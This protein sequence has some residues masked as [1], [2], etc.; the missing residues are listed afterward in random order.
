MGVTVS[1]SE[2]T[3]RLPIHTPLGTF[4]ATYSNR[5]LAKIVF[6]SFRPPLLTDLQLCPSKIKKWHCITK[7]AIHTILNGIAPCEV[8]PLDLSPGSTFECKVWKYLLK[9]PPGRTISYG[10]LAKAVT[11]SS[12]YARA[13]ARAC[14]KNPIPLVIPCHRVI[15]SNG[16]L[17][18]YALGKKWK[19]LLLERE[20]KIAR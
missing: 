10:A 9:I 18:G 2:D 20:S 13:V 19:R 11:G 4:T 6:P 15:Y 8:P 17:G 12:K 1:M 16:T 5:G 7:K 3:Y 14:K